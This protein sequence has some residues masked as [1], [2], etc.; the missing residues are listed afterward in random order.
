MAK[1]K[2]FDQ[3]PE[4]R[5]PTEGL[6]KPVSALSIMKIVDITLRFPEAGTKDVAAM[7]GVERHLI[8]RALSTP[9]AMARL[10]SAYDVRTLVNEKVRNQALVG[11]EVLQK[12]QLRALEQ[13]EDEG[14]VPDAALLAAATR[15]SLE[16]LKGVGILK[17]HSIEE[18]KPIDT[19]GVSNLLERAE[20]LREQIEAKIG[21]KIE[22]EVVVEQGVMDDEEE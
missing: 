8:P 7:C 5:T 15:I 2:N 12:V 14:K 19:A 1:P 13:L 22:A 21:K 10:D 16:T 4:A 11:F 18:T 3:T 6:L 17:D 9:M 20:V